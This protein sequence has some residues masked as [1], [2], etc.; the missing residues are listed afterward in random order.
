MSKKQFIKLDELASGKLPHRIVD[1]ISRMTLT[2]SEVVEWQQS[3]PGNYISYS[4]GL[5]RIRLDQQFSIRKMLTVLGSIM[6]TVW[7]MIQFV[8]PYFIHSK[9]P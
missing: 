9:L 7:A 8:A 1:E 5:V 6:G 2:T 3:K 4:E